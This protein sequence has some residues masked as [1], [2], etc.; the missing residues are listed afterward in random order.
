[1]ASREAQLQAIVDGY[2]Q[3]IDAAQARGDGEAANEL[4]KTQVKFYRLM[5]EEDEPYGD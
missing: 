4:F 1:M 2:E 5:L 3:E